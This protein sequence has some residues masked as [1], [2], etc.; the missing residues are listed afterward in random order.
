M[1]GLVGCQ[2]R[3]AAAD[4]EGGGAA[5]RPPGLSTWLAAGRRGR[6]VAHPPAPATHLCCSEEL[7]QLLSS[8]PWGDKTHRY[9]LTREQE[10]VGGLE[11]AVGIW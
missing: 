3:V 9:F 7:V 8:Q 10:Y 11:A 4:W 5:T 1:L 2:G 6:T